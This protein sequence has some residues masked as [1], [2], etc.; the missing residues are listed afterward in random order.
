MTASHIME[1][2][3]TGGI[4]KLRFSTKLISG[5]ISL[6]IQDRNVFMW[7]ANRRSH[8]IS[9]IVSLRMILCDLQRLFHLPSFLPLP[10]IIQRIRHHDANYRSMVNYYSDL[11]TL[12]RHSRSRKFLIKPPLAIAS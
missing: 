3:N 12:Q 7:K 1:A 11:R 6:T 9:R 5:Y 8:V 10:L 4:Q 2:L